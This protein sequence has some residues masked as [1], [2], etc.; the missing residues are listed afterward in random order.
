[1]ATADE[2][3]VIGPLQMMLERLLAFLPQLLAA[4]FIVVFGL[5]VGWLLKV[6]L[7]RVLLLL[8]FDAHCARLGL[9]GLLGSTAI[10][11]VPS[12]MVARF[13]GG[14]VVLVFLF[15]ALNSLDVTILQKLTERTLV[16]LPNL[17][18]AGLILL[19]AL[20]LGNF[21]AGAVL[22]ASVNAGN[23]LA[24]LCARLVYGL[25]L[26]LG[27]VMALEQLNIGKDT[28]LLAFA[29]AF[30]GAVLALALAFGLGGR[31]LAREFLE[32]KLRPAAEEDPMKHL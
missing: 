1:M 8:K 6:G 22:I 4:F 5:L 2:S 14:L 29:I 16:Y 20:F 3:T 13:S 24:R 17:L 31:E 19:S 25:V 21:A 9:N 11:D 23:H 12:N 28:V 18:V 27:V 26:A 7:R 30:G 32:K 15:L 10:S